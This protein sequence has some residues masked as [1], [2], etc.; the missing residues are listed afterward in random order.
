MKS[1]ISKSI[2]MLKMQKLAL[3]TIIY[4]MATRKENSLDPYLTII[5]I[6]MKMKT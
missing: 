6:S 5:I 4:T 1:F 2:P 3:S